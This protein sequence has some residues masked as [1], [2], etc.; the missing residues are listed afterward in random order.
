MSAFPITFSGLG[1][2]SSVGLS[3]EGTCAAIRADIVRPSPIET[4]RTWDIDSQDEVALTG[5]PVRGFTDGFQGIGRWSRLGR[6]ALSDMLRHSGMLEARERFAQACGFILCTP[7]ISGDRFQ[8]AS[9]EVRLL[10]L[11][12]IAAAGLHISS[13]D[14]VTLSTGINSPLQAL[15]L[16][17]Q[18][19][20]AGAW[21]RAIILAVDSLTDEASLQW[22][23]SAHRLK[24]PSSAI[25]IMP[26]E[27]GVCL[28][29]EGPRRLSPRTEA[30][31]ESVAIQERAAPRATAI[32]QGLVLSAA[33]NS[34]LAESQAAPVGDIL[35]NLNG[36]ERRALAW[37]MARVRIPPQRLSNT[38]RETW[39]ATSLG[40]TGTTSAAISL[41]LAARAFVRGYARTDA[42]LIWTL[43]D[44]GAASACVIRKWS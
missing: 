28:L 18:K 9:D 32:Q 5:H 8:F 25:G 3:S 4:F 19:I 24:T 34:V 15:Q 1:L 2:I 14:T 22:L 30:V 38:V 7:E 12:L 26:G 37:G 36:E 6:L 40:D 42:T 21:Q 23:H 16:I 17:Q 27:A 35:G 44:S 11:R 43:A 20:A 31:L 29:V 41:C 10:A 33:I 13:T 39:P